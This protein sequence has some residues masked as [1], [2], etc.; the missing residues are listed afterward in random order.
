MANQESPEIPSIIIDTQPYLP[1]LHLVSRG[2]VRDI[3]ATSNPDALLFVASDR[4]SAHDV[5]LKNVFGSIH[6]CL[7]QGADHLSGQFC[8]P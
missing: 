1:D 7:G 2:K 5:V 4:I 8:T 3:Y 6:L